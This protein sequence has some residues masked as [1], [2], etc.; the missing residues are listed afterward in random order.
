MTLALHRSSNET[1]MTIPISNGAPLHNFSQGAMLAGT[2]RL[3]RDEH[4]FR[5]RCLDTASDQSKPAPTA[6]LVPVFAAASRIL[7]SGERL[8]RTGKTGLHERKPPEI[9]GM[10][11]KSVRAAVDLLVGQGRLFLDDSGT[12]TLP[13]ARATDQN[14][15]DLIG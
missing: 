1:Q 13:P 3:V 15:S 8:T 5:H 9:A 2:R 6:A 11:R 10:A 14:L 7:M 12:L 4:I